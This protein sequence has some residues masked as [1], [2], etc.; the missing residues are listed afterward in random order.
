MTEATDIS[1]PRDREPHYSYQGGRDA[2]SREKRM[3][4][5]LVIA[6]VAGLV[7]AV[8]ILQRSVAILQTSDQYQ[9][10]RIAEI[11]ADVKAIEGKTFRGVD[12]YDDAVKP[13]PK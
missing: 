3:V 11:R 5:A 1:P 12:G 9:N 2:N 7:G 13:Q 10:E 8:W 4:D 6:A